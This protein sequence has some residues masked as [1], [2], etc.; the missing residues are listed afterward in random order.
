MLSERV[1]VSSP[2]TGQAIDH[3]RL[4]G[5]SHRGA[6]SMIRSLWDFRADIRVV[7]D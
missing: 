1:K 4:G 5:T 6:K 7:L 3:L 2:R